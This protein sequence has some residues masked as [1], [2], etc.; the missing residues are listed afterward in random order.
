VAE[1]INTGEVVYL[2]PERV[3]VF[4]TGGDTLRLTIE[5]DRS[6]L[7]VSARRAFPFSHLHNY[8]SLRDGKENEIGMIRDLHQLEHET[9]ALVEEELQRRYLIPRIEKVRSA[10]REFGMAYF[11][12]DTDKGPRDFVVRGMRDNMVELSSGRLLI[13]DNEGNRYEIPDLYALDPKWAA[14][15]EEWI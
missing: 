1:E 14:L 4:R 12:V 13:T 15:I 5:G 3:R 6:Y 11:E 7:R 10:K 2:D 9:K 8:I